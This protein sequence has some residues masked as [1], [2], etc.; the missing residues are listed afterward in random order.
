MLQKFKFSESH[1]SFSKNMQLKGVFITFSRIDVL[2]NKMKIENLGFE[3]SVLYGNLPP[4]VKKKQIEDFIEGRTSHLVATDVIG[5]GLNIPCDY[6]VFLE[7][8]KYDGVQ[9]RRLNPIEIRQ[10]AGR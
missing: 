2:I 8:E 7:I 5:M 9:N 1:F 10:I 6:L 4:E 3:C